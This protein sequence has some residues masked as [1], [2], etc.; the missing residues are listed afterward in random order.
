MKFRPCIDLHNGK[1]KQIVGGS[2]QDGKDP[3]TNFVSENTPAWYADLYRADNLTGGHVIKLGPD[4]D[5]AAR[6]ALAAWPGGLQVGGGI[7]AENAAK[8]LDAGASH[9][10]VTSYLFRDRQLDPIRLDMLLKA[11]GKERLVL[12]LSCRKRDGEYYVVVDRWQTFTNM[13]VNEHSLKKLSAYCAEFLIH[14]VDV[15]GKQ[16]GMDEAL[17]AL[18]AEHSP[19]PCVYAGGVRCFEDLEKLDQAGAGRIDVTIG[20]ALDLFGGSMSYR[21]VVDYCSSSSDSR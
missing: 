7:T 14:G 21:E 3:E 19:I 10:I 20:S 11:V 1:V 16:Q 9:V 6:E 8:W 15:E 5:A 2:L 12:D 18:L 13:I 17:I 4:N